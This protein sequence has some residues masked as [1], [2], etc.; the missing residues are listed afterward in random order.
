MNLTEKQLK[1]AAKEFNEVMDGLDPLIDPTLPRDELAATLVTAIAFIDPETDKFSKE[2]QA[3]IDELTPAPVVSDKKS[4]KDAEKQAAA[5]KIHKTNI[6]DKPVRTADDVEELEENEPLTPSGRKQVA[7]PTKK[8]KE[9]KKVTEKKEKLFSK[10]SSTTADRVAFLTP[11]IE[12]GKLTKAELVEKA[13][14]KFPDLALSSLQ[15]M[16]TDA[17]NPIYNKF[18]K[19][20]VQDKDG[21]MSFAK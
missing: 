19:L 3:V 2:T 15:T 17:K 1:N 20:V 9:V 10:K 13:Q 14:V 21:V 18:A 8:E 4:K 16:L 12:K 6:A 7:I 5:E 11:L